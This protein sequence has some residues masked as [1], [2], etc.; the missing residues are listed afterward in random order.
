[1]SIL[2]TAT[3]AILGFIWHLNNAVIDAQVTN[4]ER[5]IKISNIQISIDKMQLN[6]QDNRENTIRLGT[7]I[8][9]INYWLSNKK[10]IK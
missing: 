4:T 8:D 1:M 3:L 10:I 9:E 5:D 2:T 7:K 6:Q